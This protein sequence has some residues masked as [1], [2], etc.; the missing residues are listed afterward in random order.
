MGQLN[1]MHMHTQ[2]FNE[3]SLSTLNKQPDRTSFQIS[4]PRDLSVNDSNSH[5]SGNGLVIVEQPFIQPL[6]SQ[7]LFAVENLTE[8]NRDRYYSLLVT[9]NEDTSVAILTNLNQYS[10]N[11]WGSI[12]AKMDFIA[13]GEHLNPLYETIIHEIE[14][15][16]EKNGDW[17]IPEIIRLIG[18]LRSQIG[19]PS[20]RTSIAK[21]SV[22]VFL[23]CHMADTILSAGVNEKSGRSVVIGYRPTVNLVPNS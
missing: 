13:K 23:Q 2:N 15:R 8:V 11:T 21:Q 16:R 4:V 6:E 9:Y 22:S 12:C 18:S 10:I 7:S 1:Y 19:L 20:F 3:K 17:T 14:D 5:D